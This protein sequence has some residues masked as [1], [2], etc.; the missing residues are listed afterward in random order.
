MKKNKKLVIF[1]NT[2][3]AQTV[4]DYFTDYSDYEVVAFTVNRQ[5]IQDSMYY[6]H[7]LVPFED[8]QATYP[9]SEY[10]LFVAVGSSKLNAVRAEI[11]KRA[12]EKGY[13]L[14]TFIHP[15]AYIAPHVT[16]GENCLIMEYARILNRSKIGDGV[17]AWSTCVISH[18]NVVESF[19]YLVGQTCGFCH[20]GGFSFLG[21]GALIADHVKVAINNFIAIGTIIQSNT[22]ND[23]VY[24]GNPGKKK[25]NISAQKYIVLK[26]RTAGLS[27]G[28]SNA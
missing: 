9:P 6:N 7:V 23:S 25:N 22:I 28:E 18:D 11:I 14:P 10:D 5:Y 1:G 26:D 12:K 3:F 24:T 16:I 27:I 21:M 17:I 13:Y 20:I 19:C 8:V 4:C 15:L 2:L